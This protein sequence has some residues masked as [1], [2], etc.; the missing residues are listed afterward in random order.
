MT[1]PHAERCAAPGS[2]L[3]EHRVELVKVEGNATKMNKYSVQEVMKQTRS[4]I[5]K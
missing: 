5:Q 3:Q 2:H 4:F 1:R